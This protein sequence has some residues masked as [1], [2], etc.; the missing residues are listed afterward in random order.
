MKFITLIAAVAKNR[1]IG[2]RGDMPWHLPDE[3]RHFKSVTLGKPV[4]MG[5]KT[6]EAIGMALPGRQNIVVSRNPGFSAKGCGTATTLEQAIEMATASEVMIIGGG[7]L[8]RQ[9]MPLAGRMFLTIVDCEPEADTW[10]PEWSESEWGLVGSVAH[11]ADDKHAMAFDMQ[12]WI[13]I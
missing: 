10:F 4:I 2:L 11:S 7:E 1:A 12:E 9:A 6:R 3:L 8:Y 13:R 5:R